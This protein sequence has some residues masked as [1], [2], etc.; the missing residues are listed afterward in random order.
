MSEVD[1]QNEN[2]VVTW[3]LQERAGD[4]TT[5]PRRKLAKIS[6]FMFLGFCVFALVAIAK[7]DKT[8]VL[9][10]GIPYGV[11]YVCFVAWIIFDNTGTRSK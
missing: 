4:T 1:K 7:P 10:C 8:V 6:V 2:F 5:R 11:A 3:L 9:A